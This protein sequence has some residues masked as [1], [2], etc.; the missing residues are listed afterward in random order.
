MHVKADGLEERELGEGKLGTTN[1]GIGPSYAVKAG[2][3][4]IRLAEVFNPELFESKLRRLAAGYRKRYGDLF[5]YDIEDELARFN[6]YR[7]KLRKYA[8]DGVSFIRSAQES[9]MNIV[10]EGANAL[11]LD[12]DYG[13]YPF[14]TSS[15]TTLAGII[16]GLA[17]NPKNLTETIGVVKAY[18][19]RVGQG[20][21]KTEDTGEIGTKLQEI[22]REWVRLHGQ[23]VSTLS[24]A[25]YIPREHRLAEDVDVDDLVVVK[26]SASINY[27]SAL[28]LTKLDVLDTLETIKIA[29][30]YKVD[31]E[32]LDS[33][34]ADLDIL[35][36]AEVVY[37]EM[38]G[39]QQPTTNA[40][41]FDD[42]PKQARD[43]VEYIENFVGVQIK[44]I[45]TGPD[46]EAMIKRA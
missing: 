15:N 1:R 42:L 17:L 39:W 28:N 7:P 22:G 23:L 2:R 37:H 33:Y 32:E 40:K 35:D 46:R 36:R 9:N 12:I 10:V 29:I 8:V 34:P 45:G 26:Y 5:E 38:P 18:T 44:W 25:N 27:Y 21:F 24:K 4:G 6:E 16:G 30:A 11:M 3:S 31:G 43:Y 13:S 41:S 14:V 19:T 20:A